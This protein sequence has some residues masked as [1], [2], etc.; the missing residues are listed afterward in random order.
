MNLSETMTGLMDKARSLT[1]L[2]EK[3]SVP[4]LTKLMDH[5]DLHVNPNLLTTTEYLVTPSKDWPTWSYNFTNPIANGKTYTFS[6]RASA[7]DAPK[8]T[9]VRIRVIDYGKNIMI[10]PYFDGRPFPLSDKIQSY[11][12]T[13]PDDGNKYQIGMY[14]SGSGVPETWDCKFYDCKLEYG[15]L[16]T[17]LQNVGGGS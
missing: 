1:G 2:T 10:P 12:F 7:P 9:Q 11:T 16:A 17:P 15:D 6:W 4:Q 3:L 13:V 5:F 14:G 8:G